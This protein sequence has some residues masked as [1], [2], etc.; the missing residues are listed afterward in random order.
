M[1]ALLLSPPTLTSVAGG[2]GAALAFG[3]VGWAG[4][5]F[6]LL[7]ITVGGAVALAAPTDDTEEDPS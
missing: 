4:L 7:G 3:F 6:Y 2:M 1:R 5:G